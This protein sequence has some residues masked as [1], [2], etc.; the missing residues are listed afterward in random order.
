MESG[1]KGIVT[2][3]S[4]K[5]TDIHNNCPWLWEYEYIWDGHGRR[6]Y[7]RYSRNK[8]AS[9]RVLYLKTSD[10]PKNIGNI[11]VD[12]EQLPTE[13]WKRSVKVP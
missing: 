4:K 3:T 13:S 12:E 6:T 11:Q 10:L 2:P 1:P 5:I 7:N 8:R 9:V